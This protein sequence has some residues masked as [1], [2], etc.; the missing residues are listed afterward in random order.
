MALKKY[1]VNSLEEAEEQMRN[2]LGPNENVP[3]TTSHPQDVQSVQESFAAAAENLST[4]V[5]ALTQRFEFPVVDLPSNNK[6]TETQELEI[7]KESVLKKA[8]SIHEVSELEYLMQKNWIVE[9][10]LSKGLTYDLARVFIKK[11]ELP[12]EQML[13]EKDGYDKSLR[14]SL[15]KQAAA[16]IATAGPILITHAIPSVVLFVG[17]PGCGKTTTLIKVAR[18]YQ[19]QGLKKV[20][21][22]G[23]GISDIGGKAKLQALCSHFLLPLELAQNKREFDEALE[24]FHTYDLILVNTQ[25]ANRNDQALLNDLAGQIKEIKNLN[26]QLVLNAGIHPQDALRQFALFSILQP[27]ALIISKMDET[28]ALG[29]ILTLCQLSGLPISYLTQGSIPSGELLIADPEN[30]ADAIFR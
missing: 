6:S 10:L 25:G 19:H 20:A 9:L 27:A 1:I 3:E 13:I 16:M 4:V 7:K 8:A 26:V 2:T 18:Q 22:I 28:E 11:L 5:E 21:V 24:S 14:E 29:S 23:L 12:H 30:A 15:V 17:P